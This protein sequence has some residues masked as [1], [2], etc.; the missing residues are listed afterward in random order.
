MARRP[1]YVSRSAPERTA[2]RRPPLF[3]ALDEA[4][5]ERVL[6]RARVLHLAGNQWL[7]RQGET[8]EHFYLVRHG[9]MRLF[10]SGG[11]G[12]EKIIELIGPGETFA[13]AVMFMGTGTYPVC[14]AALEPSELISIDGPDFAAM[15]RAAPNTCLALLGVLSRRLHRMVAEI[16]ALTPHSATGRVARWLLSQRP[17]ADKERALEVRRAVLASRLSIKPETFSRIVRRLVDQRIMTQ[18]GHRIAIIDRAALQRLAEAH[19]LPL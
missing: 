9:R 16:D 5:L 7:F 3:A 1:T 11:D 4:Q 8:A 12:D 18:H 17:E 2:L 13:E 15:L 10:R 14:A 19:D 6:S